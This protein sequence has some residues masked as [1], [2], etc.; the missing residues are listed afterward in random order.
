MH[1]LEKVKIFI[2]LYKT[3]MLAFLTALFAVLGYGFVNYKTLLRIEFVVLAGAGFVCF[4]VVVCFF[5]LLV[6]YIKKME[7][8]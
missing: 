2:D 3:L 4:C 7:A 5:V 6:K 8:L 1:N